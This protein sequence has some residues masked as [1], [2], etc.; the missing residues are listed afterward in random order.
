MITKIF[1]RYT[2]NI[3][4]TFIIICASGI[5]RLLIKDDMIFSILYL[6]ILA[7]MLWAFYKIESNKEKKEQENE[8]RIR[9]IIKEE[10]ENLTLKN[11]P[12]KTTEKV[13]EKV[14]EKGEK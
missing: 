3:L 9:N 7:V 8:E 4:I 6:V 10:L 12:I 2:P 13:D 5:L 1:K 11:N 14:D